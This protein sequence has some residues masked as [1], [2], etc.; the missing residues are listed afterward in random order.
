MPSE[1]VV[2]SLSYFPPKPEGALGVLS[3][4]A[5]ALSNLSLKRNPLTLRTPAGPRLIFGT[6]SSVSFS[7]LITSSVFFPFLFSFPDKDGSKNLGKFLSSP[8][9]EKGH[10]QLSY[11]DGDE[12]GDTNMSTNISLVCKP[13]NVTNAWRLRGLPSGSRIL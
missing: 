2:Y 10:I 6:S 5:A 1:D 11:S 4:A 9:R 3:V 7:L 12:C 8:T 13:G